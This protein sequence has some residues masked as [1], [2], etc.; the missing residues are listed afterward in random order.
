MEIQEMK[1]PLSRLALACVGAALLSACN[2]GPETAAR[3]LELTSDVYCSLDGMTLTDYPGP[4]AQIH[5]AQ[6]EPEF[7]C[8]TIEMFSIYLRP[9][10]QRRVLGLYVHDMGRADW[11]EPRN[12]WTDARSAYYVVGS[13]RRG[14]M[15]PTLAS[16]AQESDAAQFAAQHGGEVLSFDQ[17]T[18]EMVTLDGGVLKD[19]HM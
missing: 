13:K 7:Y 2:A 12:E 3:P 9:E 5:Y 6:G 18:P 16:F 11:D 10:Q 19:Q 4:K 8:D 15:G 17:I 1:P 14:S